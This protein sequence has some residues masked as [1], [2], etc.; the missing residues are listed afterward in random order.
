MTIDDPQAKKATPSLPGILF[1][2]GLCVAIT[3]F[4]IYYKNADPYCR[5]QAERKGYDLRAPECQA[6]LDDAEEEVVPE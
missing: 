1:V 3:G 6:M 4:S 2:A 5:Y